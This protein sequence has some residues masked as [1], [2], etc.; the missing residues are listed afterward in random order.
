MF[1]IRDSILSRCQFFQS[2][3]KLSAIHALSLSNTC[4]FIHILCMLRS[5]FECLCGEAKYIEQKTHYWRRK[6]LENSH[7]L[8]LRL[9][10]KSSGGKEFACQCRRCKFDP[11][12]GKIPR[13]M[14]WHSTPVFLPRKFHGP[15]SLVG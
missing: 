5:W 8:I 12:V 9:T 2:W 1:L 13:S 15:T 3:N 10:L 4:I 7:Y 14:K 6:K 11:R